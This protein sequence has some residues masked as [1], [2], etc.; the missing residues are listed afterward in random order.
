MNTHR[1]LFGSRR[2]VRQQAP[3]LFDSVAS[4]NSY[5]F[6]LRKAYFSSRSRAQSERAFTATPRDRST[7]E[8]RVFTAAGSELTR[9]RH[10]TTTRPV[11]R[12]RG[13]G[14]LA[15]VEGSSHVSCRP[16]SEQS[17][18]R[19][20]GGRGGRT[21]DEAAA[22]IMEPSCSI[23]ELACCSRRGGRREVVD[24]RSP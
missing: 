16:T 6:P 9:T 5:R 19:T 12:K 1:S 15:S 4:L 8:R 7:R 11:T 18:R 3:A 2:P 17:G 13:T 21:S 22:L 20:G 10:C 23:V 24:A 14:S